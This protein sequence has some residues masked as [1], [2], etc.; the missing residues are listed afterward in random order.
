MAISKSIVHP[1][2]GFPMSHHVLATYT[3]YKDAGVVVANLN[4][5]FS[6]LTAAGG[7]QPSMKVA[8]QIVGEPDE[9]VEDWI[10]TQLIVA[11][12]E[13][14]QKV[15]PMDI[16]KYQWASGYSLQDRFYFKDG[17]ISEPIPAV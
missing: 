7:F 2:Q 5:Y 1:T 11:E 15:P 8:I 12:D 4:S 14:V 9:N 17:A 16:S 3:V 6:D 10:Y 13:N